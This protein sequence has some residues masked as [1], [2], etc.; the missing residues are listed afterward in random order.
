MAHDRVVI[1]LGAIGAVVVAV[2]LRLA[3]RRKPA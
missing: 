3:L 2:L 1:I